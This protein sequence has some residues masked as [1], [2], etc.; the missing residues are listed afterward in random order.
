MTRP[1]GAGLAP[2]A[3]PGPRPALATREAALLL[4]VAAGA[5]AATVALAR[6][7]AGMTGTMGLALAAFVTAW[8]LMMAAMMLPSVA[9]TASLYAKTMRRNRAARTAGLLT[10]YLAVWAAAGLPAY[11]LARLAGWL[12]G[13]HPAAGHGLAVGIFAACG[14]YQLTGLKGRCL[15]HCRSPVGLL[16]HYGS[17]RGR[18]RDLRAGAHHGGYCLGCCWSLMAILIAVGV[19]NIAAMVALA[20]VVLIE[21]TWARG[22]LAARVAGVAA[23][24]LAVA[25]IWVPWLAPGLHAAPAMMMG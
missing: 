7:M 15:A 21:K 3:P 25:V 12:A 8:T 22:P 4:V 6:G 19:M 24:A 20:A 23:L 17:Y 14:V 2:A 10:G 16:L 18:L 9:P 1:A 11:G 5:W 13:A